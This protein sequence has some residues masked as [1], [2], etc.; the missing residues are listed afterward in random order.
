MTSSNDGSCQLV[1]DEIGLFPHITYKRWK[2]G[3]NTEFYEALYNTDIGW[4]L[5]V[6]TVEDIWNK[7]SVS[8]Y[9]RK[10]YGLTYN[11][12]YG[13]TTETRTGTL[14]ETELD[15][16]YTNNVVNVVS[17]HNLMIH[18]NLNHNDLFISENYNSITFSLAAFPVE[19]F[20]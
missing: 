5:D 20:P 16:Y 14:S 10:L 15:T 1:E 6:P 2:N 17:D 19:M 3:R 4:G 9:L 8:G 13:G 7:H 18:S 12:I 11:Y